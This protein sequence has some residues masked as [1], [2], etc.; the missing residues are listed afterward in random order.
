MPNHLARALVRRRPLII[1]VVVQSINSERKFWLQVKAG[2]DYARKELLGLDVEVLWRDVSGDI[3]EQKGVFGGLVDQKVNA[4]ALAVTNPN[5]LRRMIAAASASHIAIVTFTMDDPGSKRLWFIGQDFLVAGRLAGELMGQF[6]GG[7][8][9]VAV[10]TGFR[11]TPGQKQ[12]VEAFAGHAKEF[13]PGIEIVGVYENHNRAGE[14]YTITRRLLKQYHDLKGIY[15]TAAGPFGSARAINECGKAG[16][17]KLICFD[18]VDETIKYIRQ[19]VIQASI[20]QDPFRQGYAVISTLIDY[21]L[22]RRRPK[23]DSIFIDIDT[24]SRANLNYTRSIRNGAGLAI[25]R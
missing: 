20:G 24:V 22:N 18:I 6:I 8:G 15:V 13:F 10:I 14:A 16:D 25:P 7:T 21:L 5:A 4:I 23:Q 3:E 12:R 2:V 19:G 1:G 17:V 11:E 9:Q